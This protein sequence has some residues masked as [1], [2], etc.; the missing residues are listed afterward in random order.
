MSQ[1]AQDCSDLEG[2]TCLDSSVQEPSSEVG[3]IFTTS[4]CCTPEHQH[5]LEG[6]L[7]YYRYPVSRSGALV[8]AAAAQGMPPDHLVPAA[9][10]SAFLGF[11]RLWQSERWFVQRCTLG[12]CTE[13]RWSPNICDGHPGDITR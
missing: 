1:D 4:L 7:T 2:P 8:S 5:L 10:G 6:S 13:S 9:R 3:A 11:T 12:H